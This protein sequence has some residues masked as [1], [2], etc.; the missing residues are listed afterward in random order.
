MDKIVL[1]GLEFHGFHGVFPE[2][3]KL[4]ARFSIDAELYLHFP[5][6]DDHEATV[7]YSQV[8]RLIQEEVTEQ[9]YEL[10]ESL[11]QT[12]A[13]RILNEHDRLEKV[14]IR[15]HKPHAP[16]PGVIRDI[17]VELERKRD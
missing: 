5:S 7:D 12:I 15:V 16:L 17:Y 6:R 3:A 4:G 9:R 2:E 1:Q 13:R 14:V 11:A 10:F 8:Y